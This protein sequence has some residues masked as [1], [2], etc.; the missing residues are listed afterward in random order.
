[1]KINLEDLKFQGLN[2]WSSH[3]YQFVPAPLIQPKSKEMNYLSFV[4]AKSQFP[5]DEIDSFSF[6]LFS[7]VSEWFSSEVFILIPP[8]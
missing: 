3:Y 4:L 1:M 6:F 2:S 8:T 5:N 7:S